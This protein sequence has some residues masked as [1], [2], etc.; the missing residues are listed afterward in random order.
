M[1]AAPLVL[2]AAAFVAVVK[3]A[4]DAAMVDPVVALRDE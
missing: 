1:I 2:V 4:R 3:P